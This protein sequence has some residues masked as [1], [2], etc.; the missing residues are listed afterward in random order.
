MI[1]K[2]MKSFFDN[3]I[4][5]KIFIIKTLVLEFDFFYIVNAFKKYR[6]N[7]REWNAQILI[8]KSFFRKR[9]KNKVKWKI[10]I[11]KIKD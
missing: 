3:F 11:N 9:T 6:L 1:K 10:T 2:N 8:D 4:N 7:K 5:S